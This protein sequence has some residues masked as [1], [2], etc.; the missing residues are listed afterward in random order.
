[1]VKLS[2]TFLKSFFKLLQLL[3]ICF[4]LFSNMNYKQKEDEL[5]RFIM[6]FFVSNAFLANSCKYREPLSLSSRQTSK[7]PH[8]GIIMSQRLHS[9]FSSSDDT[10]IWNNFGSHCWSDCDCVDLSFTFL[11]TWIPIPIPSKLKNSR[12]LL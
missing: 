11:R 8:S 5:N 2:R 4:I 6:K 3:N 9:S 1:M 10:N 12:I 7:S